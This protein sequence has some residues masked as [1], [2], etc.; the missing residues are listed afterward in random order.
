LQAFALA[1]SSFAW[2]KAKAFA[3]ALSSFAWPKAKAFALALSSFA[4][5]KA[6]AFALAL[7]S[8]ALLAS[9][10]LP[11]SPPDD[12]APRRVV[13]RFVEA[14][15]DRD[16]SA[17][18]ALIEPADWRREIGPELRSYVGYVQRIRFRSPA[19]DVVSNNGDEARVRF[20]ATLQYEI[21][22]VEPGEQPVDIIFELVRLDDTWYV[23][24]FDLPQPAQ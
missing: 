19:Y 3:L 1:L 23:R 24:S 22:G 4:W 5:P 9:C 12:A 11:G 18:L 8:F 6:K 7:S 10:A 14:L 15:E 16:A 20:S 21:E 2:P 13:E 17:L